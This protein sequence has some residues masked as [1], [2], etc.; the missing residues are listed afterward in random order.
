MRGGRANEQETRA[1][2]ALIGQRKAGE[3]VGATW[4]AEGTSQETLSA[5]SGVNTV[6]DHEARRASLSP[7]A[8]RG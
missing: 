2:R 1:R 8:K 4:G 5:Q 3:R 7:N 6:L